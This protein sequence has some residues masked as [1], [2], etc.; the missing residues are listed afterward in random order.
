MDTSIE[1]RD[2]VRE[3]IEECGGEYIG[4]RGSSVL[5]REKSTD[6]IC[7]L[8]L[9][10]CTRENIALSLKACREKSR[11]AMWEVAPAEIA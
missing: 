5:F 4:I 2:T 6:E 8:Y 9:F 7:S 11:A 3:T 1:L 10:S